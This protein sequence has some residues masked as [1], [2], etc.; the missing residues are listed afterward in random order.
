MTYLLPHTTLAIGEHR[1]TTFAL[2]RKR[3]GD[4]RIAN[5][6]ITCMSATQAATIRRDASIRHISTERVDDKLTSLRE[7]GYGARWGLI[8]TRRPG[9]QIYKPAESILSIFFRNPA[10]R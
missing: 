9:R 1:G 8:L 3:E 5:R 7:V 6:V 4:K 10:E 2:P